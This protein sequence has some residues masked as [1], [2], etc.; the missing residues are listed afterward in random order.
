M[1]INKSHLK[2]FKDLLFGNRKI[3]YISLQHN[4]IRMDGCLHIA[5]ALVYAKQLKT[6]NLSGNRIAT[7]GL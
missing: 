5:Q 7:K 1:H 2:N 4:D 6:L 3:E